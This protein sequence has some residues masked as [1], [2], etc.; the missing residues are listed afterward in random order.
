MGMLFMLAN[1][2]KSLRL[3]FKVV[4]SNLGAVCLFSKY[5]MVTVS[6]KRIQHTH[7]VLC[8]FCL[9]AILPCEAE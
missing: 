5:R 9:E 6:D 4:I 2:S 7:F 8:L 1:F 3:W